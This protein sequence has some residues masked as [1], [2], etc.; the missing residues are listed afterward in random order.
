MKLDK[1]VGLLVALCSGV[2]KRRLP[3]PEDLLL[4]SRAQLSETDI[5]R[6]CASTQV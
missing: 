4:H 6:F 5:Q 1:A 2:Q 3:K